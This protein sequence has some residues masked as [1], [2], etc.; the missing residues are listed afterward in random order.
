MSD[1]NTVILNWWLP[2][3]PLEWEELRDLTAEYFPAANKSER[4]SPLAFGMLASRMHDAGLSRPSKVRAVLEEYRDV[5]MQ[6]DKREVNNRQDYVD[7]RHTKVLQ[8]EYYAE[9]RDRIL[10][11]GVFYTHCGLAGICFD[12]WKNA[13]EEAANQLA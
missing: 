4:D 8:R 11:K 9:Y 7:D 2:M 13:R 5:A 1:D 12:Q 10:N 3:W 6:Y